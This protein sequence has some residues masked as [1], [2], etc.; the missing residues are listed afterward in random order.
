M[1][2]GP[3]KSFK[4]FGPQGEFQLLTMAHKYWM[5]GF[6]LFKRQVRIAYKIEGISQD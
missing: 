2:I 1:R 4:M 6:G 3:F 5:K